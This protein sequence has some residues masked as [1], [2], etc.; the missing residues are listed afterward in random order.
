MRGAETETRGGPGY[1]DAVLRGRR[2]AEIHRQG[3]GE[4]APAPAHRAARTGVQRCD[5]FPFA[6]IGSA[7]RAL[8]R[9]RPDRALARLS[10]DVPS[11]FP[12][13]WRRERRRRYCNKM[14]DEEN[15]LIDLAG[16]SVPVK[17]FEC[18]P[19]VRRPAFESLNGGNRAGGR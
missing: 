16:M 8:W 14:C 2:T 7:A 3:H 6:A 19:R 17:G 5:R 10:R 15:P 12:H 1:R 9:S 11:A 4:V 13:C 18:R